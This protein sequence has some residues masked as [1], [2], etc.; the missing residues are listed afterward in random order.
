MTKRRTHQIHKNVWRSLYICGS[1]LL[2]L[3]GGMS[4]ATNT[5]FARQTT[6]RL[7]HNRW[8]AALVFNMSKTTEYDY[9]TNS[10][11]VTTLPAATI[12][13]GPSFTNTTY[14][15]LIHGPLPATILI[16]AAHIDSA[17]SGE[18]DEA[19]MLW[20]VDTRAQPLAGWQLRTAYRQATFPLTSTLTLQPGEH[21]WCAASVITFALSFGHTPACVWGTTGDE[22]PSQQRLT[23]NLALTNRGGVVQLLSSEGILVDT[24]VY[25]DET[26]PITGWLGR[27]AQLYTRGGIPNTGQILY[28]KYTPNTGIP[29]DTDQ[30]TDWSG[31]LSDP[32]WGRQVWMPGW[33]SPFLP[34]SRFAPRAVDASA[35]VTVAIGPE[36]LYT[37]LAALLA[38]AQSSI[39]LSLYTV[40]HVALAE[41]I[42]AAAKRG[43]KVRLLLE[44]SPP[45]GISDYQKWCVTQIV[46]AGGDVRYLAVQEEAPAG[47]RTRYRYTHAKYGI[48]DSNSVFNGTENFGTDSM[49]ITATVGGRRGIYLFTDASEIVAEFQRIFVADWSP[50]RFSDLQPYMAEHPKYGS[51][52]VDFTIPVPNQYDV[53]SSPFSALT[54]ARGPGNLALLRAPDSANRPDVGLYALLGRAGAGDAI[55]VMQLYEHKHWGPSTSNPVA[56][57]NPR[58]EALISAARRGAEVTVLLDSYFDDS[59]GLRSNRAT[60]DYLNLVATT[61]GLPLTARLGNPTGGGIHAKLY[62]VRL[63]SERWSIVGSLNGSEISHKL[64]REVLLQTDFAT[65]YER[66]L[67]IFQWDWQHS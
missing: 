43:V 4:W 50:E 67:E 34:A 1:L 33:P 3:L 31:D 8:L 40:E 9:F 59:D 10:K 26:T 63:G 27:A 25:G 58:L 32:Q 28:R 7:N 12:T 37:P 54:T 48:V 35:T 36:G 42:A 62:L 56:D 30:A 29:Y 57:P 39:D 61:E 22:A 23:G 60:V 15:P 19:I 16:A 24:L 14:L 5:N 11:Q 47:Y 55:H 20:N 17:L 13:T 21:L 51:P 38:T 52:P 6:T 18:A 41:T 45:G 66:L 44:G 2:L 64:N 49:P 46:E 53:E 65:I